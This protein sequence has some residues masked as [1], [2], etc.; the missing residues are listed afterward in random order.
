MLVKVYDRGGSAFIKYLN[1]SSFFISYS[2]LSLLHLYEV[3]ILTLMSQD[4]PTLFPDDTK[5][6]VSFPSLENWFH[7]EKWLHCCCCVCHR[8]LIFFILQ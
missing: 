4:D 1:K 8:E 3:I 2:M 5:P 6:K 7:R